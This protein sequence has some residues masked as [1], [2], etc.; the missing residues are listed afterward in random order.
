VDHK[1]G[2][3]VEETAPD[4]AGRLKE[5]LARLL[6][7]NVFK[8]MKDAPGPNRSTNAASAIA[9]GILGLVT[10]RPQK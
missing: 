6:D 1:K 7:P 5:A 9:E 2:I 8:D 4:F 3:L 10:A